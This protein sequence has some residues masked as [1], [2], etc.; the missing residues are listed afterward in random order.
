MEKKL[1]RF[2]ATITASLAVSDCAQRV[3]G[4]WIPARR[5][6]GAVRCRSLHLI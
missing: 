5:G 1:N 4:K 6:A 2:S 3:F